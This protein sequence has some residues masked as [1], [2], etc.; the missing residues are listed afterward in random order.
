M[1]NPKI[2]QMFGNYRKAVQ[3]ALQEGYAGEHAYRPALNQ[4]IQAFDSSIIATNEPKRQAC[5]AP[6]FI[7]SRKK[8]PIGYIETKDI[9]KSLK[10]AESTEQ[11]GRYLGQPNLIL[12]D[13]LEFRW[14]VCGELRLQVVLLESDH[15]G[16]VTLNESGVS[17]F[18]DLLQRFLN[19]DIPLVSSPKDLAVLM[20][21]SAKT[22]K[23]AVFASLKQEQPFGKLKSQVRAF[24]KVLLHDLTETRFAD[25]YA[26]TICYGLFAAKFYNKPGEIFTRQS[27][28]SLIPK[29]NPFL[30][31]FFHEVAT[32]DLE[33]EPYVWAVDDLT[34]LLSRARIHDL[35]S[36][37]GK[38]T[39][40]R[41]P[42][43]HFYETFLAEYS[44][45]DRE[46]RGV[47]YTPEP[48][49]SYIVRSVDSI[50]KSSFSLPRGLAE[51]G[52][53]LVRQED[54]VNEVHKV[55]ILDPAVGTGTFLHEVINNI[56]ETQKALK[57]ES[58]QG[59]VSQ[60][61][62]PRLFGFELFIAPY[63]VA[64]MKLDFQLRELGYEFQKG[65][66]IGVYLTNTL[67]QV[68]ESEKS[69]PF[70]QWVAEEANAANKIKS[71]Y[72]VMVVLGNPPYSGK[73]ANNGPW[74]QTLLHGTDITT[75]ETTNN[76]FLL[77]GEPLGEKNVKWLYD[78]YVKFIRFSQRRI[79][80]TGYG[81]LA[82]VCNHGYIDNPT[83]KGMRYSLME[84]FD[85]L[86]I[87]DLHGSEK[88]K[89]RT[90][91]GGKDENVFDIRP[92]VAIGLFVKH[93]AHNE[94]KPLANVFHADLWGLRATYEKAASGETHLVGGKYLW[95]LDNSKE[96]TKWIQLKPTAPM[97]LFVP[98]DESLREE[99]ERGWKI[100][101]IFPLN[102]VGIATAR[103]H[104]TIQ[105]SVKDLWSVVERLAALAPEEARAEFELGKDVR[106]WTVKGAQAD[107]RESGPS[108]KNI[109]P[110]L[111]RPFDI[112]YTY[113]TGH[114]RGFHCMPRGAV[115][116]QLLFG[117]NICLITSRM[118]KG[119]TFKHVQVSRNLV[120][121]ICM[122]SKTSNNAFVFPLYIT[123]EKKKK[124]QG[125]LFIKDKGKKRVN[126]APAFISQLATITGLSFT[127][128]ERGD[129]KQT[130]GP[131]DVL[132]FVYS[133]L[134]VPIYRD[135]YRDLLKRD[136]PRCPLPLDLDQ[137][138][139]LVC[140]GRELVSLH[141]LE[142][143][144][145][146]EF[147]T[148]FPVKGSDVVAALK[149]LRPG[150]VEP[151]TGKPITL[152]RVYISDIMQAPSPF[153]HLQFFEGVSPEVWDYE[154][155]GYRV[156]QKWLKERQGRKL[157]N[158]EINHFQEMVA[159]VSATIAEVG[160]LDGLLHQWKPI[161]KKGSGAV[162]M[163]YG[164]STTG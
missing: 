78:D 99:Y 114:S 34:S 163:E 91:T 40:R 52:K 9:G 122:S 84:T 11:L 102:S 16:N 35:L 2:P 47:Y 100:T 58:W 67:E 56:Y 46:Q 3:S 57:Q 157:T 6:D 45:E 36:D 160:K 121:V 145:A 156:C 104:L 38:H 129:L 97:F 71:D 22:L 62:L 19:P 18:A 68:G 17:D 12:T 137:F 162:K 23:S 95:L 150:E 117:K 92:G 86:Y 116:N 14:F 29:T 41:D 138:G 21:H 70:G 153:S 10:K 124:Q 155:G 133:I 158:D 118:T 82:F 164:T 110:I 135:R 148:T 115:M 143:P 123:A 131:L 64:H 8:L 136:F 77:N 28:A 75:K 32:A 61:L 106:D 125:E 5:G 152:G 94:R 49:V 65:E 4:L 108:K 147:I 44:P 88:K 119:E 1:G 111:Y 144:K 60:N 81:I 120:E 51:N 72:P 142:N 27:A 132:C 127:E 103:D 113:Y 13:Y 90:P 134:H 59:Y 130:F 43:F 26:Q 37:Y 87:L 105:W 54:D 48:I 80:R 146:H 140:V 15:H 128:A 66:R 30:R 126:I 69:V 76:Y 53:I 50:L 42:V 73:S 141:L 154:V 159:S 63:A 85:D 33:D 139:K 161:F 55:L 79:E 151:H 39:F 83:F 89:E 31:K 7:V 107:L 93:S 74:I 24:Q 109:H 101:D 20:A 25:M 149:Y 112:R 98:Q 96:T